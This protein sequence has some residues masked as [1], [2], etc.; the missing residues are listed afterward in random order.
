MIN[1]IKYIRIISGAFVLM[2]SSFVYAGAMPVIDFTT[3]NNMIKEYQQ[4]KEQY[5]LLTK[6]YE[7]ARKQLNEVKE[8][9]K[10]AK[11]HYGFGKVLNR[12]V[13]QRAR[14]WSPTSWEA[15]LRG[16][17]GGNPE[18][19]QQLVKQYQANHYQLDRETYLQGGTLEQFND[20]QQ[21]AN[22]NQAAMVQASYA[23]NTL[24]AHLKIV[25]QLTQQIE[26]AN[27]TKAAIDLNS[28][29]IAELAYIEIQTLKMQ[30]LVN[31]QLA[32]RAASG[33]A[34][35]SQQVLFN[36]LPND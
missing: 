20:Y 25:E 35:E 24:D 9:S 33:I 21:R 2:G 16:L 30:T 8:I 22:V 26:K 34:T 14:H 6:T 11:G 18:R 12:L 19:Y 10:T 23:Y 4:L 27:N 29:L 36:Q 3:I 31:Q 28:R 1:I 32:Q 13:D 5:D 7:N 17:A 15:A